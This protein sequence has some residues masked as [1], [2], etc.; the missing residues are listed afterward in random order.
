MALY[1]EYRIKKNALGCYDLRIYKTGGKS[2]TWF[3]V[4]GGR[5]NLLSN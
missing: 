5:A 4:E 2:T 3:Q 1:F